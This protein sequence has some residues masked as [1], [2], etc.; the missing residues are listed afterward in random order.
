MSIKNDLTVSNVVAYAQACADVSD[1]LCYHVA[2]GR[3]AVVLPSRGAYP[4][5]K[6]AD[7]IREYEDSVKHAHTIDIIPFT[8][9]TCQEAK[10]HL[11]REHWVK[12]LLAESSGARNDEWDF[13]QKGLSQLGKKFRSEPRKYGKFVMIDTVI[14]GQ[15]AV[16]ILDA[17]ER[18]SLDYHLILVADNNGESIKSEFRRELEKNRSRHTLI[19]VPRL[20]TEDRGPAMMG[21]TTLLLPD[22]MAGS[23][24]MSVWSL[25]P[26]VDKAN[27]FVQGINSVEEFYSCLHA[28]HFHASK[29]ALGVPY[30]DDL[31][32]LN[33]FREALLEN[34]K[35]TQREETEQVFSEF[36]RFGELNAT[37]SMAVR[38]KS[39]D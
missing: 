39:R 32:D 33:I 9:D 11:V 8:F 31:R 13:Y 6:T 22:L 26:G 37:S 21:M 1:H 24:F 5:Y 12:V 18:H 36:S 14:S 25:V 23:R 27:R 7:H 15:A 17:L 4:I 28:M 16:E 30:G 38:I 19:N 35:W 10:S 3:S 20:Y 29:I 34:L 2:D